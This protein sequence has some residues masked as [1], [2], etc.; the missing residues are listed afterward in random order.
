MDGLD[1]TLLGILVV[2]AIVAAGEYLLGAKQL[3]M[4]TLLWLA[5][6]SCFFVV[7]LYA[8]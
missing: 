5:L 2:M 7:S 4:S 6:L 8:R 3:A 1:W